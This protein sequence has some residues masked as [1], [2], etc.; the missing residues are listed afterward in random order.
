MA[1]LALLGGQ[2][3][4]SVRKRHDGFWFNY[5][6]PAENIEILNPKSITGSNYT[7]IRNLKSQMEDES[8]T[9]DYS[10]VSRGDI[11]DLDSLPALMM[12]FAITSMNKVV[13]TVNQ[14]TGQERESTISNFIMA[15]MMFIPIAGATASALGATIL[16][17]IIDVAGDL[18]DIG[19][20]IYEVLDEPKNAL[21]SVFSLLLGG[22]ILK[23]FKEVAEVRRGMKGT[24]LDKLGPIKKDL[25]RID[26]LKGR[27]LGCKKS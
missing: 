26:T 6:L 20:A 17:T 8:R 19:V 16:R 22:A 1:A 15:F 18:A 5:R 12:Q 7:Q 3:S 13:T 27:G 21:L 14:I 25:G 9:A 11:V 4:R 10:A 24:E 2:T 23:P